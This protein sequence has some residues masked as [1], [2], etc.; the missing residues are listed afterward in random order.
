M[1]SPDPDPDRLPRFHEDGIEVFDLVPAE[2]PPDGIPVARLAEP[3]PTEPAHRRQPTR[4]APGFFAAVLWCLGLLV[5]LWGSTVVVG[6][7]MFAVLAMLSPNPRA[8]VD[9]EQTAFKKWTE[10]VQSDPPAG[11]P[12]PLPVGVSTAFAVGEAGGHL[13]SLV[14]ALIALRF[15]VGRDWPRRIALRRPTGMHVILAVLVLPGFVLVHQAAHVLLHRPFDIDP[16]AGELEFVI[17]QW[18]LWVGVLLIG[19][20]PGVIEELFCRGFI[21]RG[22]VG[23]YGYG[24]G[25][26]LT[27]I[28]FGA[29]HIL[30]LYAL[31]VVVIGILLHLTYLMTRSLW[32]PIGLHFGNNTLQVLVIKGVLAPVSEPPIASYLAAG[33]LTVVGLLAFWTARTRLVALD[34]TG[35]PDP[36]REPWQPREPGVELP[37]PGSGTVAWAPGPNSVHHALTCLCLGGLVYTLFSN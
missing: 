2:D 9:D 17:A 3:V 31:G 33:A 22:L 21:G 26:L 5:A 16:G 10:F 14:F 30:P 8:F 34:E 28:L 23:R 18:P 36:T 1:T 20:G 24:A 29:L 32:V 6:L 27:S 4:P 37:P 15:V 7:V 25:V 12:A 19:V 13:G 11:D 35:Q